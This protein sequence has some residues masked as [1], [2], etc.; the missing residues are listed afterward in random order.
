MS[1]ITIRAGLM[2]K[3]HE[4][5]WLLP[6][7]VIVLGSIGVAMIFAATDGVWSQGA[8][9]HVIR[10][11]FA[12]VLMLTVATIHIRLW[13]HLAYPVYFIAL[14]MLAGVDFVGV[15]VNGAQRWFDLG[16]TRIQPSELMKPGLVLA[17]ARYYHDLPEW[18]VSHI[19]GLTGAL[20]IIAIPTQF[21]LRQPDLGTTVLLATTGVAVIFLAGINWRII[22]TA[23][24][25][26]S[27]ALPLFYMYGLKDY[28]RR[29]IATFI[30]PESDP[31]GAGYHIQ[32]SKI[33][34][35]SGGTSGKGFMNGTQR[36]LEYVPEN[37]TDF[38]FTVIGEEFGLIGGLVT[39]GLYALIIGLCMR[40]AFQCRYLFSKLL[41][42][43]LTTTFALYVFINL[44]MVM[45]LAPVVGVPLPLVSYGGT[46]TLTVM[47]GFGLVLSAHL[48]RRAEMPRE[49][50]D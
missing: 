5:N 46:V 22:T 21:I 45:G 15:S 30:N 40:L 9:Q 31:M 3:L 43:G 42:L 49:A 1:A 47:L 25:L 28:Q 34:L 27:I 11:M 8:Q 26:A 23:A 29:R 16:V 35:G 44:A 32:Q 7:L 33:A 17:L 38:I 2:G 41:I 13:Y 39:M 50:R 19:F 37:R 48:Y 12:G 18:R 4:V 6:V 10:V 20:L 14:V 36:Q 24:L